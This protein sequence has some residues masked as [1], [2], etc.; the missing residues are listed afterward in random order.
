[1]DTQGAH[2][3]ITAKAKTDQLKALLLLRATMLDSN[4]FETAVQVVPH[5]QPLP[6]TSNENYLFID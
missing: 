5:F 3:H 6:Q 4:D 2:C 1:M